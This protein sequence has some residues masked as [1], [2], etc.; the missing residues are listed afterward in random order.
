MVVDP[1]LFFDNYLKDAKII[2]TFDLSYKTEIGSYIRRHAEDPLFP[3]SSTYIAF[4]K[5]NLSYWQGIS[6]DEGGFCKKARDLYTDYVLV[7][8]TITENDDFIT[9]GFQDNSVVHPNILNLE[10]LFDDLEQE[11]YKFSRYFGLYVSEAELGKFILDGNRLFQDKDNESVAHL[12][13]VYNSSWITK[14]PDILNLTTN[15][16]ATVGSFLLKR[17]IKKKN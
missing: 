4:D 8:K 13:A 17:V 7:D 6:Y 1:S 14:D 3:E 10:F 5:G 2:K 16:G 9:L 11:D 12:L 15:Y